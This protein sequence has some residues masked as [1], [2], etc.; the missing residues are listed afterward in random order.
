MD[1]NE[2]VNKWLRTTG[3]LAQWR[4]YPA[5]NFVGNWTLLPRSKFSGSRHCAKPLGRCMPFWEQLC[6]E[7][8]KI[9][10]NDNE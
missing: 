2:K 4:R 3:G 9:E 7:Q 1:K 6:V 8:E 5:D 10:K